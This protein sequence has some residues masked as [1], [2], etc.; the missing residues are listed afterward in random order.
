MMWIYELQLVFVIESE[1]HSLWQLGG[2]SD[3][4]AWIQMSTEVT[5]AKSCRELQSKRRISKTGILQNSPD[6]KTTTYSHK[7]SISASTNIMKRTPVGY[8]LSAHSSWVFSNNTIAGY[9]A[10]DHLNINRCSEWA[11]RF[12]LQS[13][14]V[15]QAKSQHKTGRNQ[16]VEGGMFLPK[17]RAFPLT[18]WHCIREDMQKAQLQR[19][20]RLSCIWTPDSFSLLDSSR[21]TGKQ[22]KQERTCQKWLETS[23]QI[24]VR[25]R[26][27]Q[28][29]A[30]N[31][32]FHSQNCSSGIDK[33]DFIPGL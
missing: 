30:W 31:Y 17:S 14:R 9:N 12:H 15:S 24:Y 21:R 13:W 4:K 8:S 11:Y 3:R 2:S 29:G 16:R 19:N 1:W 10:Y 22:G 26:Y 33:V 27:I 25:K 28:N 18:T 5:S 32:L 20:N 6:Y 23:M 7:S